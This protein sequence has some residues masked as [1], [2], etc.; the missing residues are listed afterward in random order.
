MEPKN[1]RFARIWRFSRSNARKFSVCGCTPHQLLIDLS[2]AKPERALDLVLLI[3]DQSQDGL[4]HSLLGGGPLLNVL[5]R[6]RG[7]W[8]LDKIDEVPSTLG[9]ENMLREVLSYSTIP[10]AVKKRV[11]QRL[12]R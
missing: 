3:A 10:E 9:L 1:E 12:E 11:A 2:H 5:W 7:D 6:D 8:A 4:D